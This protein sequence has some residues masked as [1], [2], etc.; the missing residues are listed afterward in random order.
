LHSLTG[1]VKVTAKAGADRFAAK[2]DGV[3]P[4][5]ITYSSKCG[6]MTIHNTGRCEVADRGIVELLRATGMS[7]ETAERTFE[8]L[9][10]EVRCTRV[11]VID[12]QVWGVP[13]GE[14]EKKNSEEI[15]LLLN[16]KKNGETKT[17]IRGCNKGDVAA[18]GE[19]LLGDGSRTTLQSIDISG[20]MVDVNFTPPTK[21]GAAIIL[22]AVG[23]TGIASGLALVI[24]LLTAL[25]FNIITFIIAIVLIVIGIVASAVYER[26]TGN[27]AA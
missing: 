15:T 18:V 4:F 7:R 11:R 9:G 2:H 24:G 21:S 25:Q 20:G 23:G 13:K 1:S 10:E 6:E 27:A 26:A 3:L 22:K 14:A 5:T 16:Y 12:G 17:A 19:A 8:T